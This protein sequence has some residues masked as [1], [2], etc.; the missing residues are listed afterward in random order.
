MDKALYISM[1]GAKQTML[2]QRAHAN[3][4]ANVN[5]TAFKSDFAQARSMPVFGEHFPTRAYAMT[6]NPGTDFTQGSLMETGR[7][8]DVAIKHEGWIAVRAP[9]GDEAFTRAGDLQIDTNGILRTG[10]G[11]E[12]LGN[13]GPIAIPPSAKVEIAADG[14]ISVIPLGQ[15][16]DALVEVDRIKLVNPPS[17]ALE[18]G[19][20]GLVRMKE[21]NQGV[22]ADADVRLESGFLE[23]SNVSAIES[24]TEILSLA[25]QYELQIKVMS[26]AEKNSEAAARLLH[27]S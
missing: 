13:G 26:T 1:T 27:I 5:T 17:E 3:N 21:G 24:L 23:S 6:E 11:L 7:E 19:L 18:K 15:P 12:V 2:A 20:D 14:T 16:A 25:R 22:P 8:L 4:M 10:V 9:E